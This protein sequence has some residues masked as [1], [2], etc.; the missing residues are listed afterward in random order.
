VNLDTHLNN[1]ECTDQI[2]KH[3]GGACSIKDGGRTVTACLP[4]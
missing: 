2:L 4:A 1:Y 3:S